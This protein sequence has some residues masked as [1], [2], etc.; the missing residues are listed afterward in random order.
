M[1]NE[2]TKK[3]SSISIMGMILSFLEAPTRKPWAEK[4]A[5]FNLNAQ[6][7]ALEYAVASATPQMKRWIGGRSSKKLFAQSIEVRTEQFEATIFDLVKNWMYDKTGL[8]RRRL[9]GFAARSQTHWDKLASEAIELGESTVTYDGANYFSASHSTGAS[10]TLKNL[11]TASEVTALNVTTPAAPTPAEAVDIIF[12]LM[13]HFK[14]FKDDAGE[15]IYEDLM[16]IIVMVPVN[17][18][19]AFL[20]ATTAKILTSGSSTKDNPLIGSNYSVEVIVNPRLTST[21]VIYAFTNEGDPAL[22]CQ[23]QGPVEMSKKAEGSDYEH[24]TDQWEFGMKASRSV[25]LFCWQAA[26]KATLS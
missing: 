16:S 20:Q 7:D 17:M 11:V 18:G 4:V 1:A 23:Q 15:P 2:S 10:G 3:L 8:L 19:P 12:G 14:T 26:L 5:H 9:A 25:G 22:I 6:D 13:N 24:D 21:T